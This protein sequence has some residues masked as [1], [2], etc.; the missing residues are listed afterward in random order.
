MQCDVTEAL[1]EAGEAYR[2]SN[3]QY[4]LVTLSNVPDYTGYA[5]ALANGAPLLKPGVGLMCSNNL[6]NCSKFN[7]MADYL[8]NAAYI[9][10]RNWPKYQETVFDLKLESDHRV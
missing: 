2:E 9:D 10:V 4:D 1:E 7:T 8:F 6:L 5:L 3:T